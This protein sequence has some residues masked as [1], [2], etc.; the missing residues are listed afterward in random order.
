MST[1]LL[2][3]AKAYAWNEDYQ[4][5]IQGKRLNLLNE[6]YTLDYI[7]SMLEYYEESEQYEKCQEIN[8]VIKS[9]RNHNLN[10]KK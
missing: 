3:K 8:K 1:N 10:Y 2:S 9:L 6:P 5:I 7:E 4:R